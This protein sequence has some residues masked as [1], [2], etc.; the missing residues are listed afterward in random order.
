MLQGRYSHLTGLVGVILLAAY[1]V[2]FY[3]AGTLYP[4]TIASLFL[5]LTIYLYSGE[6][7]RQWKIISGGVLAGLLILTVPTFIF[8]VAILAIWS[9]IYQRDR[10][11]HRILFMLIPAFLIVG[12]WSL[13]NFAVLHDFVF[14]STNSGEN[15]LLGNSENTTPNGGRTIDFS[16]YEKQA[17]GLNEVQRD[18]YFRDQ[19]IR[20]I[21]AHKLESMKMYGL[22]FLN[23]F[24]YRN[25]L[26]TNSEANKASD[27]LLLF[28]YGPLLCLAFIR[29]I[30]AKFIP[31]TPFEVLLILVYL[32]GA[33]VSAIFFTRI[34]FRIPFDAMLIMLVAIFISKLI[35]KREKIWDVDLRPRINP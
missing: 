35:E 13:R 7:F 23:F 25:E 34:R 16:N 5:I 21:G 20:Y 19:A 29:V 31:L 10:F 3:T 9:L 26:V 8:L 14:V 32:A 30:L 12:G 11:V 27:L 2:V 15:L 4:Q 17:A 33:A 22:K 18:Q 1:P 28:T 6:P 24:N